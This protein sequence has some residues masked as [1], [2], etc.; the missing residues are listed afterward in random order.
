VQLNEAKGWAHLP[1]FVDERSFLMNYLTPGRISSIFHRQAAVRRR[2]IST[3]IFIRRFFNGEAIGQ[4]KYLHPICP[5]ETK[6]K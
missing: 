2:A 3:L 5:K 4:K 6:R 1:T